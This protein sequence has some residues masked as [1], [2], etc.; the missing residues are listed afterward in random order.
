[1]RK[2]LVF[3]LSLVSL[4]V[5]AQKNLKE[6]GLEDLSKEMSIKGNFVSGVRYDDTEGTHFVIQAETNL[7]TPKSA[8]EASKNYELINIDGRV[9]T[10]RN[11]EAD[12]RIKGLFSYHFVVN[13]DSTVF[14]WKHL[15]HMKDC[16]YNNLT[17]AYL[18][19]PLITDIDNNGLA[20]V[21]LI[22]QLG[23]RA[24]NTVG[25]GMKL[26]LYQG[27]EASVIRGI[28]QPKSSS[29]ATVQDDQ[30]VMPDESFKALH[31]AIKTYAFELW[32]KYKTE[33]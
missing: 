29:D 1:M 4:L 12:F 14:I 7:L 33:E 9:D 25:L 8:V 10:I 19:K 22:Y 28:R 6:I 27:K 21:W 32:N 31:P 15:D 2:K 5:S 11:I 17:A 24:D 3:V 20:E 30:S 18:N 16:V 26:V 23:C 13:N